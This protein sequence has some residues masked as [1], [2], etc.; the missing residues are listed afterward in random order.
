MGPRIYL[1]LN[2]RILQVSFKIGPQKGSRSEAKAKEC[3]HKCAMIKRKHSQNFSVAPLWDLRV[4]R[5][6]KSLDQAK[7]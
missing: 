3:K 6:F 4:L 7:V 5:C 2:E 1:F